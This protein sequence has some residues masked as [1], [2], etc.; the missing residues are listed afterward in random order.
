MR[1]NQLLTTGSQLRNVT[2][3]ERCNTLRISITAY[4]SCFL[5]ASFCLLARSRETS[6]ELL[7]QAYKSRSSANVLSITCPF[8]NQRVPVASRV[9]MSGFIRAVR[10]GFRVFMTARSSAQYARHDFSR[11]QRSCRRASTSSRAACSPCLRIHTFF[12]TREV[13]FRME[14]DIWKFFSKNVLRRLRHAKRSVHCFENAEL[15]LLFNT[16][17]GKGLLQI[18]KH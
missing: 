15:T 10:Y 11:A 4:N 1:I 3:K 6:G 17:L 5:P 18:L 8:D 9:F 12:F 7:N 14:C 13:R 16:K 2:Q